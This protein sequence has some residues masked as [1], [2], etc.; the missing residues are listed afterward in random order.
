MS[1]SAR[2][3]R[4]AEFQA[5]RAWG[6]LPVAELDGVTVRLHW[7]DSPYI[8]H[9]NDGEEVFVVLDGQVCMKVREQ[10]VEQVHW[11]QPGDIFHAREGCEHVAHPQGVA[12]VLVVE[13][14][15]SV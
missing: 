6:A 1:A 11:L 3:I 4:S 5:E 13:R 12:R 14:E 10:G 9:V 7:T 15:G 8:W 2:V